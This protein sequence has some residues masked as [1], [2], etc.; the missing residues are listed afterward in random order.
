[1][2]QGR[3]FARAT[4]V[5]A[6]LAAAVL[7]RP[8]LVLFAVAA[9]GTEEFVLRVPEDRI[10]AV[11]ARYGLTVVR[12]I[13]EHGHGVYLVRRQTS[14]GS[15]PPPGSMTLVSGDSSGSQDFLN[16]IRTDPDVQDIDP[17]HGATIS[18]T[19]PGAQLNES[20]VAILDSLANPTLT[21]FYGASVWS[22]YVGQPAAQMLRLAAAQQLA[23]GTGTVVAIIDTGVDPHHAILADALVPGYDFTR[24]SP[25]T[26]SEW[27]DLDES[28]VAILDRA[29]GSIL[30]PHAPVTLN[31]STVAILDS[32]TAAQIDV[33]NLPPAFGH[34]TMVAGLVH[35]VAPTAKIMPLKAFR[36]D[37]TSNMFDIER[38]IYY[39][40]D[41]GA[42]V[43][44][45]S[46]S[47]A[48]ASAELTQAIDYATQHGVICFGSAGNSGRSAL[49]FPAAFRNVMGIASTTMTDQRSGFSN[50]GDHMVR[51]AAPGE[52]LITLYPGQRYASVSGTSFSTAL[53]SGASLLL[54]QLDP[55]ADQRLIGRYFDDAAVKIPDAGLGEGRIE[56][57]ATLQGTSRSRRRRHRRQLTRLPRRSR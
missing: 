22:Y 21:N 5:L 15:L 24:D 49:V 51:F 55:T 8:A 6:V 32:A 38:A 34:G 16:S 9:D 42:K 25:G 54:A 27:P 28:T 23:N 4:L 12:P 26:G 36:A 46:F 19:H 18:E 48:A 47:V 56:L 37:G 52:G 13:D 53:A 41:H 57:L 44:N 40:V 14:D 29:A 20:T 3:V 33:T 7:A 31:E 17:N 2:F 35:L 11:A 43:I 45:M 1:M 50:Y 30:D 39:A 10:E